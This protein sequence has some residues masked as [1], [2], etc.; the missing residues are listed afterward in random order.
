MYSGIFLI[1]GCKG[2]CPSPLVINKR[3]TKEKFERGKAS[4]E[5]INWSHIFIVNLRLGNNQLQRNGHIL[6]Y[7]IFADYA[8]GFVQKSIHII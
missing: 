7:I 6:R 1:L 5:G 3:L 8:I 2:F 4:S